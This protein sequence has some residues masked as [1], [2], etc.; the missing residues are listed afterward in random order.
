M[1]ETCTLRM[2]HATPE[3]ESFQ[4][5][6]DCLWREDPDATP[7]QH[8]GWLLPWW[9]QFGQRDLRAV[10]VSK[11]GKPAAL[12][13]FYVYRNPGSR[14]RQLLLL[15]VS[16]SDYLDGI[17]TRNC[18]NEHVG[19][20]IRLLRREGNWDVLHASQ[21]R[22]SSRLLHALQRERGVQSSLGAHCSR[23]RAVRMPELP[24]KIRRNAMYYRNRAAR[25]GH[26]KF[27][28]ATGTGSSLALFDSLVRLHAAQW[29][30]RGEP[31]VLADPR[32][33]ACH[34]E[35]IPLLHSAD[36][37]R[38]SSLRLD[39]QDIAVS[40][41]LAD[42]PG[43]AKRAL[44][45]YLIAYSPDHAELRPGT[46]LLGYTIERAAEEGI[47]TIDM[48][49]GEEEYKKIW[50]AEPAPTYGVSL[51]RLHPRSRLLAA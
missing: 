14:E 27:M 13:P 23:L 29:K 19:A 22:H 9:R 18:T 34:R 31:G 24:V 30:R 47:E 28:T 7:F 45:I 26:L 44:Y 51:P 25:R 36:L 6:W 48:L 33:L 43:R 46:V 40:Y 32:V 10:L 41:S 12:L 2:L 17:F 4:H 39:G 42:P 21:L 35:A 11:N 1:P 50:H 49:R 37:L 8:P 38:I 16:T 3:L 15:G 20:A 5:A